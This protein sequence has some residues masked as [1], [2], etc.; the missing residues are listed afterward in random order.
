MILKNRRILISFLTV[1]IVC[2]AVFFSAFSFDRSTTAYATCDNTDEPTTIDNLLADTDVAHNYR[3]DRTLDVAYGKVY[4]LQQI[5]NGVDVYGA[6][7]SIS[8]DNGGNILSKNGEFKTVK[9][10]KKGNLTLED[11]INLV[12][13]Q[14]G[15]G[16]ILTS[17]TVVFP[18]D[19]GYV[20]AYE[21]N[22]TGESNLRVYISQADGGILSEVALSGGVTVN[23]TQRDMLDREVT[24]G[25]E[26]DDNTGIYSMMDV[27]R[28]ITL[29]IPNGSQWKTY[30]SNTN[31]FSD[32]AAVTVYHNMIGAYDFYANEE[33][34]G[35]SLHGVDGNNMPLYLQLHYG[36]NLENAYYIN[37]GSYGV[38]CIGDGKETG[39]L[40]QLARSADVIGHEYQHGVTQYSAGLENMGEAGA[41]GEAISDIFGALIEG[42]DPADLTGNF[43][44]IGEYAVPSGKDCVRSLIG[45]TPLQAY[46]KNEMSVCHLHPNGRHD[47]SCDNN[48]VHVNST[49]ITHVQYSLSQSNPTFFNRQ[50]IGKLWYTTL[51]MLNSKSDFEDFAEQFLQAAINLGYDLSVI[52][53]VSKALYDNGLTDTYTDYVGGNYHTVTFQTETGKVLKRFLVEDGSNLRD[54]D[55]TQ[56]TPVM[57]KTEQYEYAFT[58]WD[59]DLDTIDSINRD[60]TI[61]AKYDW[62]LRKFTVR[63]RDA[64]NN[65]IKEDSVYYGESATPPTAPEKPSTTAYD[66][67]FVGWSESYNEVT[68]D[69]DLTPVYNSIRY[70]MI[71]LVSNG[72]VIGSLRLREGSTFSTDIVPT[73]DPTNENTYTFIGWDKEIDTVTSDVTLN[74]RFEV[75]KR[76]Y[77]VTYMSRGSLYQTIEYYYGEEIVLPELD[78]RGMNFLG[79]FLNEGATNEFNGGTATSD[80]VLY[81]GW[82][83]N[84][85]ALII[86]IVVIVAVV[87]VGSVVLVVIMKK[88]KQKQTRQKNLYRY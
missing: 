5:F 28:Q 58:G 24:I 29:Y 79:W 27:K 83:R 68:Y 19:D 57:E 67:E 81:A 44:K 85:T 59:T 1:A 45:G 64:S 52:D 33:N 76:I 55:L 37:Y 15:I 42:N 14:F 73:R 35:V 22:Y 36:N 53:Q 88:K 77:T 82:Q 30:T 62:Q 20:Y 9:S 17:N 47:D 18:T 3:L 60:Y 31:Y 72:Q 26:Y 16:T 61:T 70:Y 69:M 2:L 49:V 39:N 21:L 38:I 7:L 46:H 41:L 6:E 34:L 32:L 8:V 54:L 75:K 80:M 43:W 40:Y 23:V 65:V 74:A 71:T 84:Y 63:F 56:I 12:Y 78:Y 13:S 50:N 11:A 25:V 51:C 4:K 48:Y 10:A 66:Y 86:V 87:A